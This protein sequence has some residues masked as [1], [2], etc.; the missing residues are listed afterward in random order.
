LAA[1]VSVRSG[2]AGEE[3]NRASNGRTG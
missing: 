2:D 1:C 3:A